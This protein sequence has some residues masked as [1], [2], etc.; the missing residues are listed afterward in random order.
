MAIYTKFDHA[1]NNKNA[2]ATSL[3]SALVFFFSPSFSHV[4][5][6]IILYGHH[7][8]FHGCQSFSNMDVD[9]TQLIHNTRVQ[10]N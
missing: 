9:L 8:P 2:L 1:H 7:Q 6:L 4:E 3:S 10:V 5:H